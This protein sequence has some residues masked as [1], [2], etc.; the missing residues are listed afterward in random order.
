MR[1]R[2]SV[3]EIEEA[4]AEETSRDRERRDS[5]RRTAELR[6]RKRH[7]ER[8]NKRGSVRYLMLV[9]TLILTAALV[10]IVMFRTLYVLLG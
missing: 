7:A 10:T 9:C 8:T 5:L 1:M 3:A 4:F 6:S 2:Q